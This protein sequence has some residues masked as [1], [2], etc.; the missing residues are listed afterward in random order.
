MLGHRL[1]RPLDARIPL[2]LHF[3]QIVVP[4]HGSGSLKLSLSGAMQDN[5]YVLGK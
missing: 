3:A 2:P 1:F 4:A 5:R